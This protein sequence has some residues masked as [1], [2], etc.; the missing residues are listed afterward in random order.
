MPLTRANINTLWDSLILKLQSCIDSLRLRSLSLRGRVLIS[1]SLVLSKIWYYTVVAP[2]PPPYIRQINT[3]LRTLIWQ[4]RRTHPASVTTSSLPLNEGGISYPNIE[5]EANICSIK[6]VSTTFYPE[7]IPYWIRCA[8][9]TFQHHNRPSIPCSIITNCGTQ[10]D[11]EPYR[12]GINAA[13]QLGN[14][15]STAIFNSPSLSSLRSILR[16]H[17]PSPT[18]PYNPS[19]FLHPFTWTEIWHNHRPRKMA[20]VL[21]KI[22]HQQIP[23]GT[24][25]AQLVIDGANCPWCPGT[26]N[27]IAHLFNDCPIMAQIWAQTIQVANLSINSLTPLSDLIHHQSTSHQ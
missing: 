5:V 15:D 27:S 1:K 3:L 6:I 10:L 9:L 20:D 16:Y 4:D 11:L 18:T 22:G 23:T 2:P 13:R 7:P 12:S 14:L 24:K 21:W 19:P 17:S 25:V 8:N 26:V